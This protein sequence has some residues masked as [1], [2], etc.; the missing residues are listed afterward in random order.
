MQFIDGD[1]VIVHYDNI[2]ESDITTVR[3]IRCTTALRTVIDIAPQLSAA[4]LSAILRDCLE[5]RLFSLEE[6]FDRVSEPDMLNRT[7]AQLFRQALSRTCTS[8]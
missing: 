3:G 4:E 5:R 2:P 8:S 1:P 7:G 6:A